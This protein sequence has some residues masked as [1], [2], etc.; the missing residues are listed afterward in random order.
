[1]AVLT[2]ASG[3]V[4]LGTEQFLTL[5]TVLGVFGAVLVFLVKH[6]FNE[7]TGSIKE[8]QDKL[9][10]STE[11]GREEMKDF[12]EK[13]TQ[14]LSDSIDKVK[15]EIKS[16]NDKVNVRIEKLQ[17]ATNKDV[18][19]L[20][21]ELNDVKGDFATSFVLRED[22]FRAMNGVEDNIRETG[23]KVD[24]LLMLAGDGKK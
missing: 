24:R 15:A 9:Q 3:A 20:K 23:R 21:Q 6:Q 13:M 1:M 11:T 10:E 14:Q 17:E 18:A 19:E 22:F 7:I 4:Y 16:N 12:Q 5:V 8:N 2:A